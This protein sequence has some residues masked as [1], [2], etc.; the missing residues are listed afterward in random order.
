MMLR[1]RLKSGQAR[2]CRQDM[3]SAAMQ[4]RA[5]P[6]QAALYAALRLV[7]L[8]P[9]ATITPVSPHHAVLARYFPFRIAIL[10]YLLSTM[11]TC[12]DSTSEEDSSEGGYEPPPSSRPKLSRMRSP[13]LKTRLDSEHDSDSSTGGTRQVH[14]LRASKEPSPQ[15]YTRHSRTLPSQRERPRSDKTY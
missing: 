6:K 4:I 13:L 3:A 1:K 11:A 15:P 10:R 2:S 5:R 8:S 14:K 9:S 12:R 7:Y